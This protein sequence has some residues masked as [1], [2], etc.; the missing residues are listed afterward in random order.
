MSRQEAEQGLGERRKGWGCASSQ[1]MHACWGL[2][3]EVQVGAAL[4]AVLG[5]L[6]ISMGVVRREVFVQRQEVVLT[7]ENSSTRR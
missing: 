7:H 6:R 3:Q 5:F 2:V 4:A 1:Q